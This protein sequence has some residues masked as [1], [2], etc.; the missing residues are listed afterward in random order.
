MRRFSQWI[1]TFMLMT[2]AARL[3]AYTIPYEIWM[4]AYVGE[5]KIGYM[6]YRVDKAEFE[7][8]QGYKIESVINNRL[9]ILGADLTQLITTVIYTD[10]NSKPLKEELTMSSGGKATKISGVFKDE[11]I[12]CVISAGSGSSNKSIPIP[13]GVTLVGDAMFAIG[14][15]SIHVGS[16]YSLHYFNP[17][18]LSVE[19]LSAKAERE[20]KVTIGKKKFDTIV[21]KSTSPMGEMTIWQEK[22]GNV[23]QVKGIMGISMIQETKDNAMAGVGD[24]PAEDLAVL[25]SIKPN[26]AIPSAR[27]VKRLDIVLGGLTSK[28]IKDSRQSAVAGKSPDEVRFT[29]TAKDFDSSKSITRP[30]DDDTYQESL[31]STPYIDHDQSTI[32]KQTKEILGSEKNAYLACSKIRNWVHTNMKTRADIG[33][34]RS[35]SDVL[36]SKV[37]VCRDYAILFASL[38]RSAGIPTRIAAGLLYLD[39]SFYYHA[40]DECYV[41]EWVPFDSTQKTDFVDA[42]HIKLAEGDATSMFGLSKVIGSLKADIKS[43]E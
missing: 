12:E 16:E 1:L 35:G 6:S 9:A 8:I 20:E 19:A 3:G 37:G 15:P 30:V 32:I 7:G 26:R 36:K 29:I 11:T 21:I 28:I 22:N 18:T 25:T 2:F 13:K 17:L 33:I 4:G 41:G 43:F 42:T 34:T 40:W 23:V 10:S 5:K 27:S 38:A 24:G 39:G 31:G 14:D